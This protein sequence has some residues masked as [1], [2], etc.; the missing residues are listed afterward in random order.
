[1]QKLEAEGW[2]LE[3]EIGRW[4][5]GRRELCRR[6]KVVVDGPKRRRRRHKTRHNFMTTF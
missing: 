6:Q 1:M 5:M 4:W 3:A 2:S